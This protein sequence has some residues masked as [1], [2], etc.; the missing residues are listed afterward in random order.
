LSKVRWDQGGP[1]RL[2]AAGGPAEGAKPRYHAF[3]ALRATAIFLVIGLH[4]ALGYIVRDIPGVLWC[5]RDSPTLP[6]FD[7]FCWWT[8]GISNPLYFTI[9][10]FFAVGL[11]NARGFHGFLTNRTKRVVIPFLIGVVTVLPACLIAWIY[12]WLTS[13]RCTWRQV[14]RFRFRDPAIE[15]DKFGS[16]HLWFLEYLVFMLLAYALVRLVMER[17]GVSRVPVR[18]LLDRILA[19][20]WRA[21]YLA[22]P[23]TCVLWLS[24]Q[25]TGIDAALDR[26]NSFLIN[27][28]KMMHHASFFIV[29]VALYGFRHDLNRLARSGWWC[30]ALSTAVFV[31]RAWLLGKDWTIPL[32]G[33]ESIAL[34]LSG[35]LFSWLVVFGFLGVALRLVRQ[36][37]G[38][39][40]YLADSSYW[41]Y[42]I[43]MPILGLLQV[44]LYRIPGHALWKAPV[45]LVGTLAIGLATYQTLVRHTFVGTGLHGYRPRMEAGTGERLT[46]GGGAQ[47]ASL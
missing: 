18:S 46:P 39:V 30:L 13:N 45:V 29:G 33:L 4:A 20:P 10:G 35:A 24:R 43:H 27:P 26:H 28:V 31:P 2:S 25:L 36:S 42:L 12:G 15:T 40:R 23:T 32:H 19:S 11:Y 14:I 16:G 9:A 47:R 22:V 7:W 17:K 5:V 3:D 38:W 8:M 34:A 21:F 37:Y 44:N 6:A 41:V 1:P